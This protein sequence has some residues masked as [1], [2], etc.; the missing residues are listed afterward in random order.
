MIPPETIPF[1]LIELGER[2]RTVYQRIEEL[3]QSIHDNGLIQPIVLVPLSIPVSGD[4]E[5]TNHVMYG[6]DAGG[7]RFAALKQLGVKELYHATTSDPQRPGYVLKGEDQGTPLRRLFTEIAENLDR[8][9]LDWRDEMRLLTRAYRLAETEAN[10]EGKHILMRDF[11]AMLG[12]GYADL[13]AATVIHDDVVKNP[14]RYK[15]CNGIRA[16]Y[17]VLLKQNAQELTKISALKSMQT[18]PLK[19]SQIMVSNEPLVPAQIVPEQPE[20]SVPLSQSFYNHNALDFMYDMPH[21]QFDHII[22]DPD[23]AVSVE[24]LE[25]NMSNAAAG[26]V[27]ESVEHSLADMQRFIKLSWNVIKP[28]GFLVFFY[29]L[30]HHE[31]LQRMAIETGYA[32]QRWPLIWVKSD[33]RSNAAPAHNF[34]KNIEYAMVCRKPSSVLARAQL[35]SVYTCATGTVTRDFGHP[36]AKP[37]ELWQW[38]YSAICIKGQVVYDPFVG[39]GSSAVAAIK[40]GLRPIGSE[41]N[42]DHYHGLLHNLQTFY[43]KE[44]GPHVQF[45]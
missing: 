40:W 10:A 7:R 2:G 43:R 13:Q 5:I 38:I 9:N 27:Q 3:A 19:V 28:Q 45:N 31:K 22:T 16:A 37:L 4:T 20:I 21:S 39:R 11:G 23:Y 41:T 32:V 44:L 25:S 33:Y 8:D 1:E 30:D 6:L 42:P 36:F 26:V 35:S 17:S 12:V 14:E 24:L 34:C 29:D 15:D 18:T